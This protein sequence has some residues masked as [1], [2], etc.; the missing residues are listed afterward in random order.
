MSDVRRPRSGGILRRLVSGL[1]LVAVPV[2]VALAATLAL[3]PK[4]ELRHLTAR[5]Q[6]GDVND[7]VEATGTISALTNVLVGSQ[8][9]GTITE[10]GADFNSHVRKGDVIAVIDSRLFLGALLQAS[11]DLENAQANVLVAEAN[12]KRAQVAVVQTKAESERVAELRQHGVANQ[13]DVDIALANYES[14]SASVEAAVANVAQAHAQVSQKSAAVTVARA[15]LDYTVIRSPI[16]G[17]VVARNV[18]IGQTVAASL[19]APTIFTIAQDLTKML[20]YAKVDE[21]DVGRICTTRGVKFKVD[22]FP[23]EVFSGVIRQ[24][25]MNPTVVQNVVTYDV[26]I[27]CE[28]PDLKLFLGMTAYVTIPVATAEGVLTVPNA[29]LHYRPPMAPEVVRALYAKY[30]VPEEPRTDAGPGK[31]APAADGVVVWKKHEDGALEPIRIALGITD[32]T[33]TEVTHVLAGTLDVG[34]EVV[35]SSIVSK[36]LPPGAQGGKR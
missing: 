19:Q 2:G 24:V 13:H 12:K 32:H 20:V 6:K 33:V 11:A 35:T 23:R 4:E 36:T 18:E 3:G 16:E 31:R 10:L 27:E 26:V 22:A 8:V 21:S 15:N 28:N 34:D 7:T 14:A 5:V 17:V 1:L 25:R 29:A 30:G 9:S